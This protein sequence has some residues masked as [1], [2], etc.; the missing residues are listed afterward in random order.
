MIAPEDGLARETDPEAGFDRRLDPPGEGQDVAGARAVVRDDRQCVTRGESHRALTVAPAESGALDEPRGGELHRPAGLRP[1]RHRGVAG[2]RG[3]ALG[4]AGG[5]D[6]VG[7]ERAAGAAVGIAVLDHHRLRA[8]DRQ[9]G[10]ADLGQRG[11]G[12]A[13]AL[14][15]RGDLRVADARRA[16]RPQPVRH[17]EDHVAVG[18]AALEHAVPV[19]EATVRGGQREHATR[20]RVERADAADGLGD[21]LT[22]GAHVLDRRGADETGNATQA[23]ETGPATRHR[24]AHQIVPDL[25]RRRGQLDRGAADLAG[26][27]A[28]LRDAQHEAVHPA[29]GHDEVRA[30]AEDAER[31]TAPPG[32][33]ERFEGSGLVPGFHEEARWAAHAER[34]ER[35]K[36]N[37]LARLQTVA[38]HASRRVY[39]ADLAVASILT[40]MALPMDGSAR[41]PVG[42]RAPAGE[43]RP[44]LRAV[45]AVALI[46]GTVVGAGNFT[47]PCATCAYLLYN[48]LSYHGVGAFVGVGVLAVG[49]VILVRSKGRGAQGGS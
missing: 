24:V 43:I 32:P 9:D 34:A 13:V 20:R 44:M 11:G 7:E 19:R 31:H 26:L 38:R 23:F 2:E 42:V 35:C 5:H 37:A 3:H 48:G 27:D 45:D 33:G 17:L 30:A 21:L 39:T 29:I 40:P 46:V 47:T 41:P 16:A 1:A 25:P 14:E 12:D 6:R 36:G 18:R 15:V 49:A 10:L 4:V 22:V 28:P 8:L